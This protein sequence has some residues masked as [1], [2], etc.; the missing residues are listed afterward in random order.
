LADPALKAVEEGRIKFHPPRYAD[1]YLRWLGEK[2]DWC[3]SRQLWW[4]HRIPVWRLPTLAANKDAVSALA[5]KLT[6]RLRQANGKWSMQQDES[7]AG[8]DLHVCL[9]EDDAALIAALEE[10][11]LERDP[12]VLDTW[13]SSG[14]WPISVLGWPERN[15][16]LSYF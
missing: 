2:R 12:D 10:A 11:G 3:I 1:N 7:E 16:G 6:Q 4:G 14:L 5:E 8:F 13:F 15:A 9:L